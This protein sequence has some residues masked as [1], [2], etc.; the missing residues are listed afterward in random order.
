MMI[1]GHF[2]GDYSVFQGYLKKNSNGISIKFQMCFK[3]VT[4][5]V[6]Q[7]RFMVLQGLLKGFQESVKGDSR[8]ME[9]YLKEV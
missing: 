6:F 1:E 2:K 7:E 9:G 5:R 4:I 3:E 8:K